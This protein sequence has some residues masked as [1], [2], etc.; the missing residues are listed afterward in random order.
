MDLQKLLPGASNLP[1]AFAIILGT[2]GKG[3]GVWG[4]G[5]VFDP[6]LAGNSAIYNQATTADSFGVAL[7]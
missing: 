7:V 6:L 2:F 4:E 5:P 3:P 1:V